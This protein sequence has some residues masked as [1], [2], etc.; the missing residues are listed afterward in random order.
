MTTVWVCCKM[1]KYFRILFIAHSTDLTLKLFN[2]QT[3]GKIKYAA[4]SVVTGDMEILAQELLHVE[5]AS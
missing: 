1:V 3:S 4:M 2:I 5:N